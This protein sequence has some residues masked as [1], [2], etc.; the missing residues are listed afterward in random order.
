MNKENISPKEIERQYRRKQHQ[1]IKE[2]DSRKIPMYWLNAKIEIEEGDIVHWW[3]GG[4]PKT[5]NPVVISN[6]EKY[7]IDMGF[8]NYFGVPYGQYSTWL[9]LYK[10]NLGRD[11]RGYKNKNNVL[12]AEVTLWS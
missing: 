6:Y 9:D 5:Q 7:Y 1:I 3:G 11:I 12:G 8:G 2:I 10:L 4:L